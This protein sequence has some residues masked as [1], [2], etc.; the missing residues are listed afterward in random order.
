MMMIL[1]YIVRTKI[2]KKK[3]N[4]TVVNNEKL[5][6]IWFPGK[7]ISTQSHNSVYILFE[8]MHYDLFLS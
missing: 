3:K 7:L 6:K 4:E 1:Y 8:P 2:Y 5:R